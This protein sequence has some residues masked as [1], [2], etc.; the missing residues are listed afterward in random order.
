M[1]GKIF[2]QPV[3]KTADL[4][5]AAA[6]SDDQSNAGPAVWQA[7]AVCDDVSFDRWASNWWDGR[8][9]R[10]KLE[11]T[12]ERGVTLMNETEVMI[13]LSSAVKRRSSGPR[14]HADE[15]G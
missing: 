4:A 1:A 2:C 5:V 10:Y 11:A 15:A 6:R 14:W 8:D 13:Q 3:A 9:Q 12:R 7:A